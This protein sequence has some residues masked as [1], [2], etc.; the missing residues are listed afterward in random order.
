MT[1]V[2]SDVPQLVNFLTSQKVK[3]RS[4]C[5]SDA[6]P[7]MNGGRAKGIFGQYEGRTRDLGVISTTL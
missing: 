1:P 4:G 7:G 5:D 3:G 2:V 6:G